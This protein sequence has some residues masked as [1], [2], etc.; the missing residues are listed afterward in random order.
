[1]DGAEDGFAEEALTNLASYNLNEKTKEKR[2]KQTVLITSLI[3]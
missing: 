2:G 1:V 3:V